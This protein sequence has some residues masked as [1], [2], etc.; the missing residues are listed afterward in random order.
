MAVRH[1]LHVLFDDR[2][3][4]QVLGDVVAG[5]ADQ[6]HAP[7]VGL[8][9]GVGTD[10]GG[11]ERVVNIDDAVRVPGHE[12]GAENLHVAGQYDH[13]HLPFQQLQCLRFRLF[14]IVPGDRNVVVGN[15]ETLHFAAQVVVVADHHRNH[16][17]QI[18]PRHPP[19]QVHDHVVMAGHQHRHALFISGVTDVPLHPVAVGDAVAEVVLQRF[20][21][22]IQPRGLEFQA[23]KESTVLMIAGVLIQVG[24][25][26]AVVV[27]KR[28]H[29]AD[30]AGLVRAGHQ[31]AG[32]G[33][34]L[35][36]VSGV[37]ECLRVDCRN[38][39]AGRRTGSD[40]STS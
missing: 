6:F 9:I 22:A 13:V 33:R 39:R 18:A 27:Q 31:Q 10:E 21:A 8:L 30:D 38:G 1:A 24:N 35:G 32:G 15:A 34:V 11:Q 12:G 36:F 19:Q 23:Q 3:L 5:G 4:V 17:R 37:H 20:V 25:V 40:R 7:V 26:G 16:R 28:G 29:R 14:L 2:P